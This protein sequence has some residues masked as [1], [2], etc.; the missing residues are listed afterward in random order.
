MS[1]L[2]LGRPGRV[3]AVVG[4][5][6]RGFELVLTLFWL[7][8]L[9]LRLLLLLMLLL[10]LLITAIVA[11]LPGDTPVQATRPSHTGSDSLIG[12]N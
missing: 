6:E 8:S 5:A 11:G 9:F 1:F 7:L 4:L 10:M 2:V 3:P 12:G